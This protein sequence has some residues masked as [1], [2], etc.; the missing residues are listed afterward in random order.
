MDLNVGQSMR[1]SMSVGG[2][3]SDCLKG[4]T[5][6][7]VTPSE[8]NQRAV[9]PSIINSASTLSRSNPASKDLRCIG[10]VGAIPSHGPGLGKASSRNSLVVLSGVSRSV[11]LA[12]RRPQGRDDVA[13]RA[14]L[15]FDHSSLSGST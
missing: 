14:K 4:V 8:A 3:C 9:F 2:G 15:V 6:P 7:F 13:A 10:F 12:A 5:S 1:L 11:L